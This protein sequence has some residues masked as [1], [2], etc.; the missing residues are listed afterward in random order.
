MD[1]VKGVMFGHRRQS[2]ECSPGFFGEFWQGCVIAYDQGEAGHWRS[3]QPGFG[4]WYR[5]DGAARRQR[6]QFGQQRPVICAE[7]LEAVRYQRIVGAERDDNQ[8]GALAADKRA[9]MAGRL[10]AVDAPPIPAL[11]MAWP[12]SRRGNVEA[13]TM[14]SPRTTMASSN[15]ASVEA[16]IC[17]RI[18]P[19]LSLTGRHD[20]AAQAVATTAPTSATRVQFI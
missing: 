8:R 18:G 5:R 11:T 12:Q 15:R 7:L 4:Q 10:L 6:F 13:S 14:L 2:N 16:M 9:R 20:Q 1:T 17:A 3:F 19:W